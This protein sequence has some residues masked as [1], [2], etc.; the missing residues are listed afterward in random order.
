MVGGQSAGALGQ[1]L[2]LPPKVSEPLAALG[3]KE[4]IVRET[5]P[6]IPV[7][8]GLGQQPDL[9]K[10]LQG[11][12]V[13]LR[14]YLSLDYL[15]LVLKKEDGSE[16]KWFVPDG[17]GFSTPAGTDLIPVEQPLLSWVMNRHS[18]PAR[19]IGTPFDRKSRQQKFLTCLRRNACASAGNVTGTSTD[20]PPKLRLRHPGGSVFPTRTET[21]AFISCLRSLLTPSACDRLRALR[22]R[23]IRHRSCNAKL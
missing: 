17:E 1:L 8:P 7:F 9:D 15:S 3:A 21:I 12:P 18:S 6:L 22:G 10:F 23:Y 19:N 14:P 4:A 11:L 13:G 20:P 2:K 5:A 16:R